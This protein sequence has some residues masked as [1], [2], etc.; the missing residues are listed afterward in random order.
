MMVRPANFYGNPQTAVNNSFQ[1]ISAEDIHAL[2]LQQFDQMVAQLRSAGIDVLLL[3]DTAEPATPDSIFPNNWISFHGQT[4][5]LYPMFAENRRQE[6]KTELIE[7]IKAAT[8]VSRIYDLSHYEMSCKYLEGTGSMVLD[9]RKNVVYACVSP[10]TCIEVLDE[11]CARFNYRAVV[12]QATDK[13]G[14]PVY[15]TNVLMSV[16]EEF[17][18]I[19]LDAVNCEEEKKFLKE[20]IE[21]SGKAI[22]EISVDQMN[23]FCGNILQLSNKNGSLL[24]M[25]SAAHDNF[26]HEQLRFFE[27]SNIIVHS[28]LDVIEKAGGGSAR[29]M[30][31]EIF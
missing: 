13:A 6:R 28:P 12:F 24:V 20:S 21:Y 10:R 11:F 22:I 30:I 27:R 5:V 9:R 18:V 26:N 15:H 14:A 2:A 8:S 23:N 1:N 25:S 7:N 4:A 29:C 17:V 16:A 3:D 19:C 31:A